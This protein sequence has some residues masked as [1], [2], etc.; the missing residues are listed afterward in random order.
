MSTRHGSRQ[1]AAAVAVAAAAASPSRKRIRTAASVASATSVPRHQAGGRKKTQRCHCLECGGRSVPLHI[2]RAH[3]AT[4]QAAGD[5]VT[6]DVNRERKRVRR[7]VNPTGQPAAAAASS[8][9]GAAASAGLYDFDDLA[10]EDIEEV[11]DTPGTC[12]Q[13][14]AHS[15][16]DNH[17]LTI[18]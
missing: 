13:Q 9:A 16:V 3:G 1:Q 18:S 8:A 17:Q 5:P 15:H 11:D 2:A 6:D 14:R 10:G 7:D 12:L 4:P